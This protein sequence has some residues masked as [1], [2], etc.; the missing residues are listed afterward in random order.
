MVIP[1][2]VELIPT[3]G[4]LS[5]E[6]GPT[7]TRFSQVQGRGL[8]FRVQSSGFRIHCFH[9]VNEGDLR[10]GVWAVAPASPPLAFLEYWVQT[11]KILLTK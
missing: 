3:L 8:G 11:T 5:P 9:M 10:H 4:A 6:A 2:T 7:R 1:N